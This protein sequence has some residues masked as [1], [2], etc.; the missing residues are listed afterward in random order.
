LLDILGEI[1]KDMLKSIFLCHSSSDKSEVRNLAAGLTLRGAKVWL[2]EAEIFVGDSIIE[3]I[4]KG[5]EES[6]FLGIVLSPRSVES[7][8]VRKEVEAALTQ[9]IDSGRVKV[10]PILLEP[11]EIPL[12]LRPKKYADYSTDGARAQ[13]FED[14]VK[15]LAR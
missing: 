12:F 15:A 11:C 10:M 3:K 2:D 14:I 1:D 6:D 9:E 4:Q 5:I 8:W 13:G 7:I